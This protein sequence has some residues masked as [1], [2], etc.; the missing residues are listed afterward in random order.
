M[1]N[2]TA[3]RI[4]PSSTPVSGD[5]MNDD[6]AT[7]DSSAVVI[8]IRPNSRIGAV[9]DSSGASV[10]ASSSPNPTQPVA[11]TSAITSAEPAAP[12]SRAH[13][14]RVRGTGRSS[15]KDT[16]PSARSPANAWA[17]ISSA[18]NGQTS[19]TSMPGASSNITV[20]VR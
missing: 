17:P 9:L 19:P 12:A 8:R 1:P 18:I 3:A 6:A 20:P 10:P 15:R 11:L 2:G 16:V 13:Q 5:L 4:N 7:P 14:V